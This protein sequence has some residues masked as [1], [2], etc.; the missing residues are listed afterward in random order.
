MYNLKKMNFEKDGYLFR[1]DDTATRMYIIQQGEVQI[2][3]RVDEEIFVIEK[4]TR[5]CILNH[6]GF[7]FADENDT[8]ARCTTTVSVYALEIDDLENIRKDSPELDASV[9]KVEAELLSLPNAI[10]LDYILKFPKERRLP[11]PWEV[12]VKR[13]HLTVQLKNAC[14]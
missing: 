5:G 7:L 3:H 1:I 10:A 14:T 11:R 13:N 9:K 8:N 4:L 2:E 12:E 6:R